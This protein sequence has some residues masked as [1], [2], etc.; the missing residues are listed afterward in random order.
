MDLFKDVNYT[1]IQGELLDDFKVLMSAKKLILS[2]STFAWMA[3]YLGDAHEVH[4]PSHKRYLEGH[5]N[6]GPFK[7]TC[8]LYLDT[9]FWNDI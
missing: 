4:M 3:A 6:L 5:Q 7:N 8:K 9:V 2:N 1:L